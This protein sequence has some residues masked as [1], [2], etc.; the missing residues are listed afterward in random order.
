MQIQSSHFKLFLLAVAVALAPSPGFAGINDKTYG[1]VLVKEITSIFDG[2]SFR[3][4]IEGWPP[5]VGD[6]VPV[7]LMGIDTPEMRGKC[8]TEKTLVRQAKRHTVEMLRGAKKIELRGLKRGKYF[9][10]LAVVYVDGESLGDSL[11]QEGLAVVY[12][13]GTRIDWCA[14]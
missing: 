4:N 11:I 13:G 2:D 14:P 9:R 12:S 5:I 6:R 10:L 8:E 3:A 1:S 7:R